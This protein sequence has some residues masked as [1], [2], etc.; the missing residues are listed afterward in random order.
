M[1]GE[2]IAGRAESSPEWFPRERERRATR[3]TR[4]QA[5][6][7]AIT[8]PGCHFVIRVRPATAR[9]AQEWDGLH[10]G[11]RACSYQPPP[12]PPG[13]VTEISWNAVGSFSG[14]RHVLPD[15]EQVASAARA[16]DMASAGLAMQPGSAAQA[17]LHALVV[18]AGSGDH[19]VT[20]GS[21]STSVT[22]A[23]D[24]SI[25]IENPVVCARLH[26]MVTDGETG[27]IIVRSFTSEISHV[28]PNGIGIPVKEVRGWRLSD[29][30]F[31]PLDEQAISAASCTDASTGAPLPPEHGVRY[32]DAYPVQA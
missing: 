13:L 31:Y 29:G 4:R 10:C 28:L 23:P 24:G 2:Q 11:R 26:R 12:V 25:E 21:W 20:I 3:A 9:R 7:V 27:G 32:A 22:V 15:D 18:P 5:E 14:W 30:V 6:K 19:L 1:D 16:R 17:L 8:C